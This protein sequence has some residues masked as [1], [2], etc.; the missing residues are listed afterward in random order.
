MARTVPLGSPRLQKAVTAACLMA[1]IACQRDKA[2]DN[3]IQAVRAATVDQVRPDTVERYSATIQS[4]RQV[5]LAF[6]SAGLVDRI[7]QVQG[8]DG[9]PRD[10]QAG[11]QVAEGTELAR[12]RAADY[13][14]RVDQA[15]A[16]VRQSDAQL[17]QLEAVLHQAEQDE[18]RTRNLFQSASATK[19]EF[20]QAVARL[21]STRAQMDA[22]RAAIASARTSLD[23]AT[24]ALSDTVVRAPFSGWVGARNVERGSLVG[25]AT[26]G[27]SLVDTHLVKAVFAVPDT[28]LGSVQRGQRLTVTL[29]ALPDPV[30]GSITAIAPQADPR[31]HVFSVEVTL[32]NPGERLRPGMIGSLALGPSLA[33]RLRLVVPLSAIV[34]APGSAT[35][36]AVFRLDERET[37]MFAV[38][39][40]V[41]IGETFGNSIEVTSGVRTGERVVGL[42]GELLHD[43]EAVRVLP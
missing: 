23:Q 29:D 13:E 26:I 10:V 35:G 37:K 36:F 6:K 32:A 4:F 15:Q 43:G 7:H 25:N 11:D 3:P 33:A 9:R 21:Q 38:A 39:Q 14:Q 17:A 24:L 30:S 20:D 27:F 1:T 8:A 42:G 19:P 34:R 5:D 40:R 16:Q 41:S 18:E 31:T 22:A 2:L 12:V 28:S